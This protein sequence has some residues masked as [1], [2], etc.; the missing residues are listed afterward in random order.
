DTN[1]R[2]WPE[3]DAYCKGL[4]PEARL[5]TKQELMDLFIEATSATVAGENNFE[6]CDLHGW[7]MSSRCSGSSN[8][9]W[10]GSPGSTDS[11]HWAVYMYSGLATD[12]HDNGVNHV[13]CVR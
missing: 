9:Y 2:T 5:P 3:A 8:Y 10:T 12:L 7:P 13:T 4:T 6:M 1:L 11:M